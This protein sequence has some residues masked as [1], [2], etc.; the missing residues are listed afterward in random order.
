MG[1]STELQLQINPPNCDIVIENGTPRPP[2]DQEKKQCEDYLIKQNPTSN[3][4]PSATLIPLQVGTSIPVSN[5]QQSNSEQNSN[6]NSDNKSI[7]G[8]DTFNFKPLSS[9]LGTQDFQLPSITKN[10]TVDSYIYIIFIISSI[11]VVALLSYAGIRKW[12]NMQSVKGLKSNE[13]SSKK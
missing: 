8:I 2:T 7:A 13:K 6:N 10:N 4:N 11:F 12:Q 1:S 3:P 5:N 9:I